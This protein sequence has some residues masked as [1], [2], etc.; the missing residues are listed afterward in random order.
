MKTDGDWVTSAEPSLLLELL[1][2]RGRIL[3]LGVVV[4]DEGSGASPGVCLFVVLFEGTTT[5]D[6]GNSI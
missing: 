4:V 3:G 1:L 6:E 2:F 5:V